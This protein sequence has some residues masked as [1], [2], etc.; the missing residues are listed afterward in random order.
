MK[1]S[2]ANNRILSLIFLNLTKK[3]KSK[4]HKI[5]RNYPMLRNGPPG[6]GTRDLLEASYRKNSN[7][8]TM[9]YVVQI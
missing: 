4:H 7:K 9:C 3:V 8:L 2:D 1:V 5:S 6:G